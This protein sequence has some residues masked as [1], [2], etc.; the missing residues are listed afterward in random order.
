MEALSG[1]GSLFTVMSTPNP[2][3][4]KIIMDKGKIIV[5]AAIVGLLIWAATRKDR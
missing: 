5:G 4:D 3:M 2:D 1:I